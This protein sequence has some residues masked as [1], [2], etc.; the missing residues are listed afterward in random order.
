M[1]WRDVLGVAHLT[2]HNLAGLQALD[3]RTVEQRER[4][5]GAARRDTVS[6]DDFPDVLSGLSCFTGQQGRLVQFL[7][8]GAGRACGGLGRGALWRVGLRRVE[9]RSEPGE[10]VPGA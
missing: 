7:L 4:E 5:V 9:H 3:E 2:G 10:Q 6:V 1:W 8:R